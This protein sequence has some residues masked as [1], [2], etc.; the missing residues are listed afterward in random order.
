MQMRDWLYVDDHIEAIK[1][2]AFS[3]IK[4]ETYNIGSRNVLRNKEIIN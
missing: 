4:N 2:I 3:N 1:S